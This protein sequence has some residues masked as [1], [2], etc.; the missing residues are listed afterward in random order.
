MR[1]RRITKPDVMQT[2][3]DPGILHQT[4]CINPGSE[5][6]WIVCFQNVVGLPFLRKWPIG[7]CG[8][9]PLIPKPQT[10]V[11]HKFKSNSPKGSPGMDDHDHINH[12]FPRACRRLPFHSPVL[13]VPLL[14]RSDVVLDAPSALRRVTETRGSRLEGFTGVVLDPPGENSGEI[15]GEACK[16]VTQ[17][18]PREMKLSCRTVV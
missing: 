5:N 17:V 10:Q 6:C 12:E 2:K 13:P 8:A 3:D 16:K 15:R 14:H 4:Q 11:P 9:C 1:W 18:A 7:S